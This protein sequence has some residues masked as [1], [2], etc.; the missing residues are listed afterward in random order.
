M[1]LL[2]RLVVTGLAIWLA[3]LIVPG[4]ELVDAEPVEQVISLLL[5]AVIFT[6][7]NALLKPVLKVLTFPLYL[8]TL[9]LFALVVNALLLWLTGWLSAE[10]DL[11]LTVDGFW[12][13]LLGALVISIVTVA[14]RANARDGRRR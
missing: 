10:L 6:V 1:K 9:G 7:C 5:I 13:A 2:I 3:A 12:S 4:M 8:V 14:L 11:G